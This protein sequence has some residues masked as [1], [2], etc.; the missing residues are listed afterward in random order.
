MIA[1]ATCIGCELTVASSN[2]LTTRN[3]LSHT[4]TAP[5][6]TSFS[7]L[8]AAGISTELRF[9]ASNPRVVFISLNTIIFV[10]HSRV[11]SASLNAVI[12]TSQPPPVLHEVFH[13]DVVKAVLLQR[14]QVPPAS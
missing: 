3:M 10:S 14:L 4:D 12:V 1:A 8:G 6:N 11:F 13:G 2:T 9:I 5:Y 7:S